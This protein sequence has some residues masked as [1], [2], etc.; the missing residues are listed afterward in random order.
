MRG[1]S[2]GAVR[3]E[4]AAAGFSIGTGTLHRAVRG[5]EGIRLE[6]MKKIAQ[7][8][9][10]TLDQMLRIDMGTADGLLG[11]DFV[12]VPRAD[13][14]FSN[15]HGTIVYYE[16]DKP[17]LVF[18]KD[19]LRRMGIAQGDAVVVD[20]Q[21]ESNSPK[22]VDGAVVLLNR[23]DRTR[24]DGSFFAFRF[25]GEL[26]IKHLEE[27][28]DGLVLATAESSDFKPKTRIYRPHEGELDIIGK[29]VWAGSLL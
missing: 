18:R 11:E 14:R 22:I 4:M 20:A 24:L 28:G 5:D 2:I 10:K 29:A 8:F 1:K 23:G 17:P 9:D 15:G 3:A 27:L 21:G 26:L 12:Q 25:D 19:F 6:S 13:V 16:D 7:F